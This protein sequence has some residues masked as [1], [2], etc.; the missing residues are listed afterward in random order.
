MQR[1]IGRRNRRAE[2]P[3]SVRI[4][5]SLGE[6]T[7]R[8]EDYFGHPVIEASRLCT[9]A[10]GDEVLVSEL[11]RAMAT[12][13][14]HQLEEVG[15]LELKGLTEPLRTFRLAWEERSVNGVPLPSRLGRLQV[16]D[17][18]GRD[19]ERT[20]LGDIA[21][22]AEAGHRQVALISGEPGIGKTRLAAQTA[23]DLHARGAAV[24]V[25]RSTEDVDPPHRPWSEALSHY[26]EHA[27]QPVVD[28][29][30]EQHGGELTRLAP[31]L[32]ERVADL[33][34]PRQT[35]AET[36]RYLLRAAAIGLLLEATREHAVVVVLDDL[37]WADS[38]SLALLKHLVSSTADAEL[39][40]LGTHR[41]SELTRAHPLHQLLGDLR[42]EEGVRRIGLTGLGKDDVG[43]LVGAVLG[44]ELPAE[45][46][47]S[48]RR[49]PVRPTATRSTSAR[50]S[51]ISTKPGR[52]P[53]AKAAAGR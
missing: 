50:S 13:G 43:S 11:V 48:P 3:L 15:D 1:K 40:V 33:P 47:A 45:S 42:R 49:S 25:G 34:P 24:L 44:D 18:V 10:A 51:A 27:P 2:E 9:A 22:A 31:G 32:A 30:V 7:R 46:P 38:Q 4:G 39:L 41:D 29:H 14:S 6:A 36:E 26:V 12:T 37:Q 28:R 16:V 35:D 53:R 23:L 52:S 17:F 19:E 20:E 8:E 21:A 5:I